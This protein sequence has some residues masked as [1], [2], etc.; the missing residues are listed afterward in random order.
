M[1]SLSWFGIAATLFLSLLVEPG[2]AGESGYLYLE[3]DPPG[4]RVTID[5]DKDNELLA[6]V[7]C[8]LSVGTH[9]LALYIERYQPNFLD[10]VITP[11]EVLRK[12]IRF[13]ASVEIEDEPDSSAV[14]LN[15]PGELTIVTDV[16][17]GTIYVDSVKIATPAPLTIPS[18]PA[19]THQIRIEQ[20][21]L[22]FDTSVVIRPGRTTVL[23]LH[24]LQL[25]E[26]SPLDAKAKSVTVITE[27]QFPACRYFRAAPK[28]G[29]STMDSAQ[30]D[31][32]A[33]GNVEL[34]SMSRRYRV[35]LWEDTAVGMRGV[36]PT[37][38]IITSD[39]VEVVSRRGTVDTAFARLPQSHDLDVALP[40]A[41]VERYSLCRRDSKVRYEI[42]LFVNQGRHFTT[43]F[44][45]ETHR[46]Q[47]YVEADLN[48]GGDVHVRII[49]DPDGE[50]HFRY[51]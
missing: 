28:A 40:V 4:A 47:F 13:V 17:G 44:D 42:E 45:M 37:V 50:V 18:L 15:T 22:A 16:F 48:E 36:D 1:R 34:Y 14:L 7:L 32:G 12:R 19:G 8:T 33:L 5:G 41:T 51:W 23:Q 2:R 29:E 49:I 38:R 26:M 24:L 35:P 25:W 39:G 43:F 6:P 46:R 30:S 31:E 9:R 3:T 10:V 20:S 11:G 21:G 27:I